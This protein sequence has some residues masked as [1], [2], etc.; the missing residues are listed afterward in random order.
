MI[1]LDL[2]LIVGFL[3]STVGAFC[4]ARSFLHNK[5]H[6]TEDRVLLWVAAILVYFLWPV[7]LKDEWEHKAHNRRQ[8]G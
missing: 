3:Y 5:R 8:S 4:A 1:L 6:H 2:L 7:F